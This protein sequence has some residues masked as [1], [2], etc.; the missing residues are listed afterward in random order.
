MKKAMNYTLHLG[1]FIILLFSLMIGMT[2]FND[3]LQNTGFFGDKLLDHP[4]NYGMCD[5][6]YDWGIRHYYY[7]WMCFYYGFL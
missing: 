4:A 2:Y 1:I 7:A 6:N 5:S 3:W